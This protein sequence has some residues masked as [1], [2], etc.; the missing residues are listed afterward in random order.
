MKVKVFNLIKEALK[1]SDVTVRY[2]YTDQADNEG[3]FINVVDNGVQIRPN[4]NSGNYSRTESVSIEVSTQTVDDYQE[5]LDILVDYLAN[6]IL[7]DNELT[8]ALNEY[9]GMDLSPTQ[10]DPLGDVN[11]AVTTIDIQFSTSM[12]IDARIPDEF[13]KLHIE[14]NPV[15]I[16]E[17]V[18]TLDFEL[19]N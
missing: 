19:T 15:D 9:A 4:G 12:C 18:T 5:Q 14:V 17:T 7:G 13:Q 1:D 2:C 16:A 10:L 6:L 8:G 11:R 3:F